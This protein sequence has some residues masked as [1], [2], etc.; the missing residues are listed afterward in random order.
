MT[1]LCFK[2]KRN[3]PSSLMDIIKW[4]I[5]KEKRLLNRY[6]EFVG[7]F[8]YC[9]IDILKYIHSLNPDIFNDGAY[10]MLQLCFRRNLEMV[11]WFY[12]IISKF[13]TEENIID[14]LIF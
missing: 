4:M 7:L 8:D 3:P 1:Y 9:E 2:N 5:N 12:S 6:N 13:I 11:K 14:I 10:G